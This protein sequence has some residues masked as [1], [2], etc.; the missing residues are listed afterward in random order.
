MKEGLYVFRMRIQLKH[1][2]SAVLL[3]F[4]SF[5]VT[6]C[7]FSLKHEI[8][9]EDASEKE[10]TGTYSLILYGGIYARALETVAILAD[11]DSPYTIEPYTPE[12]DYRIIKRLPA[13]E[14]LAVAYSFI[15]RNP[16]FTRAQTARIVDG[17][18]RVIGYEIRPL[19][20]TFT[21]AAPDIV[22]IHYWRKG[23]K[24][25]VRMSLLR[26]YER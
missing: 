18:G 4:F 16:D 26:K 3:L 1:L 8:R 15:S 23:D 19:Y 13:K 5:V 10:I 14:A 7:G 9:T 24:V 22:D 25:F 2:S 20:L 11:E 12:Y 17:T 21:L 6:A